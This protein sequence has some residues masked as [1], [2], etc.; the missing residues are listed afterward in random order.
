MRSLC[1]PTCAATVEDLTWMWVCGQRC[2][3]HLGS[4]DE[5]RRHSMFEEMV[6]EGMRPNDV[7]F[8]SVLNACSHAGLADESLRILTSMEGRFAVPPNIQTPELR[9]GC[10]GPSGAP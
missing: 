9:G 1:S 2:L 10:P 8:V 7:T 4:T 6:G 3:Q 5:P